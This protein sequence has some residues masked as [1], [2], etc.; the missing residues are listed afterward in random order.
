MLTALLLALAAPTGNPANNVSPRTS[1]DRIICQRETPTGSL[2]TTREV[3]LTK[4]EWDALEG[5]YI[6]GV[7]RMTDDS[8]GR[9][10][11]T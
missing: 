3:C 1:E 11:G 4:A 9:R 6:A 10:P 5:D 2:I 8:L 7:R